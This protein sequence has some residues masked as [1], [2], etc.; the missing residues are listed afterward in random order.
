[1]GLMLLEPKS[2]VG[3]GSNLIRFLAFFFDE[4]DEDEVVE[5]FEEEEVFLLPDDFDF[6]EP[7][8]NN[9]SCVHCLPDSTDATSGI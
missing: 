2:A 9:K 4:E 5:V 8:F 6:L 7:N 1:M 3:L